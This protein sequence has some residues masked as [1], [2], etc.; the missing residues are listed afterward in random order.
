MANVIS[1]RE[2]EL[3][4]IYS[5]FPFFRPVLRLFYKG[6]KIKDYKSIEEANDDI[7]SIIKAVYDM[8]LSELNPE[9]QL[10]IKITI[11]IRQ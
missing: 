5:R 11:S 9:H 2:I 4:P 3:I 7:G 8:P 10:T 1:V 6:K